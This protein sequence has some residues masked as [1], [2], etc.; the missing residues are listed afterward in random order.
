MQKRKRERER[1]KDDVISLDIIL[2]QLK[3]YFKSCL[4]F[5][6]RKYKFYR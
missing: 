1:D 3:L 2:T 5:L 4:Y 6:V